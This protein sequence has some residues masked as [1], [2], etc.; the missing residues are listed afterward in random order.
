MGHLIELKVVVVVVVVV[1]V[2]VVVVVVVVVVIV[3]EWVMPRTYTGKVLK[4]H[5]I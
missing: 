5:I 2:L 1:V 4:R 3:V